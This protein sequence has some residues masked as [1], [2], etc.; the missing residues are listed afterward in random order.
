MKYKI[1]LIT[2]CSLLG[3]GF[4]QAQTKNGGII[5]YENQGKGLLASPKDLSLPYSYKE[6]IG[7]CEEYVLN[8]FDNWRLPTKDELNLLYE[9]RNTI[10]GF[11][12][13]YVYWSSTS[14]GTANTAWYVDFADG[15]KAFGRYDYGSGPVRC[16]R[17]F[18]ANESE[19]TSIVNLQNQKLKLGDIEFIKTLK[20]ESIGNVDY[21]NVT[22]VYQGYVDGHPHKI[23][24]GDNAN[25][26]YFIFNR[27]GVVLYGVG[28]DLISA[29][30]VYPGYK[31]QWSVKQMIEMG[32]VQKGKFTLEINKV[33]FK[34]YWTSQNKT[35]WMFD[36]ATMKF[37][38]EVGNTDETNRKFTLEP[39]SF[40]N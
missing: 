1:L 38:N 29:F 14:D 34:Y 7:E 21:L 25:F 28:K 2:L 35:T 40:L 31:S 4:A 16:V 20:D 26:Q 27:N 13:T 5:V 8:G 22:G 9:K 17:S 15:E 33:V 32:R 36:F 39:I 24:D 6:S 10:G 19:S 18:S 12:M 23:G 37:T 30:N 3:T 11:D